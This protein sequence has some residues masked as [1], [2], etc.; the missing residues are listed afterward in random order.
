MTDRTDARTNALV[1]GGDWPWITLNE[2][3]EILDGGSA[4]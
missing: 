1:V 3:E 4:P 2:V